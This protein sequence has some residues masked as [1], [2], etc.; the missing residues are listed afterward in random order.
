MLVPVNPAAEAQRAANAARS[1]TTLGILAGGPVFAS[2][3]AGAQL[4]GAPNDIVN[5][6]GVAQA[7]LVGSVAGWSGSQPIYTGPRSFP[8][9]FGIGYTPR[10]ADIAPSGAS[11]PVTLRPLNPGTRFYVNA[12]GEILDANTYARN[13]GFRTGVRDQVWAAAVDG[14]TGLVRDPLSGALMSKAEPWDMGHRAGMEYWK[15]R[16]YAI[17]DWLDNQNFTT[18]TQFL[19]KMNDPSRYRPELP[20]SNRSHRAEDSS[21]DF[22]K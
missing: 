16:D 15:E 20:S 12:D 21:N 6:F 9:Q 14:E 13:S 7:G 11:E 3:A 4:L 19:D 2:S 8:Q 18:R 5:N 1:A 22:W 17:N 10:S